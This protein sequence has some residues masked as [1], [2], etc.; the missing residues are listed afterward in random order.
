MFNPACAAGLAPAT[1][2]TFPVGGGSRD[3]HEQSSR[4]IAL[5]TNNSW[6]VSDDFELTGGL[7]YTR[8]RKEADSSYANVGTGINAPCA[9]ALANATPAAAKGVLCLTYVNPLFNGLTNHQETVEEAVTGTLKAAWYFDRHMAYASYARGYKAGG[10]NLDRVQSGITPVRDTGFKPEYVDSFELGAKTNWLG[11]RLLFNTTLFYQKVEDFQVNQFAGTSYV[12]LSAPEVVGKGVD[13]DLI[14]ATPVNGLSLQGGVNYN[15]IQ[16]GNDPIAG[17][18]R[19]AGGQLAYAPHWST[20]LAATYEKDVGSGLLAR[21]NISAKYS[22]GYDTGGDLDPA[23]Y[24]DGYAVVNARL[25][26]GA[27]DE[28]W[29]LELW[30]QNLFDQGYHQVVFGAPLQAGTIDS[31]LAPPRTYG[32]TLRAR[33]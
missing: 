24:Q 33:Y 6:R 32:V 28:R 13:V 20:T 26:L 16:F 27:D 3:L 5:F 14:W 1:G 11:G 29:M 19:L 25:G 23:K 21:A 2:P 31:F 9:G 10:F 30:A 22:S 7:R 4:S 8:E 17:F 12:V 15:N 18:P